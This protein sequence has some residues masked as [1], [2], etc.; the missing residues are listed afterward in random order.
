MKKSIKYSVLSL[1]ALALSGCAFSQDALFPSLVGSDSQ[2]A[3]ANPGSAAAD[4]NMPTIGTTNFQPIDVS[5]GSDTGTFVGQKVIGFRSDLSRLQKAIQTHNDELQKIRTSIVNNA[6]DYHKSTATIESRLQVGTT[7]GNPQMYALLQ[8]AQ[9]N[10]QTMSSST[11]A[12]NQL[13][14]RVTSDATMTQNL[15][16]SIRSSYAISGAVD[17]DHRQLRIL[18]NETAQTSI[19]INS[20]LGEVNLDAS[21]QQQ[22]SNSA[23]ANLVNLDAAIRQGSYGAATSSFGYGVGSFNSMNPILPGAA[24]TP[25]SS[26]VLTPVSAPTG[27]PL[28]K[29]RFTRADVNYKQALRNA[30]DSAR[31]R[32]SDV[33][34]DVVAVAN[35]AGASGARTNANQV[36]QDIVNMGVSADR[37]TISSRANATNSVPEVQVFVR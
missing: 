35:Q 23:N 11:I 18:E 1:L 7:P 31:S 12:L 9:N 28:F 33:I 5:K 26:S 32:R 16:D 37:V 30:V 25:V 13:S 6:Q 34:F 17:E 3:A 21:R 22:F 27:Q 36:F 29:V 19:L 20:L 2:E 8:S 14:A 4:S 15:L 10:V 24:I